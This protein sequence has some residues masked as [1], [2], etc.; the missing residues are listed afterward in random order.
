MQR[1]RRD[2]IREP[3]PGQGLVN[4]AGPGEITDP[5]PPG[6]QSVQPAG[7]ERREFP[8]R[9]LRQTLPGRRHRLAGRRVVPHYPLKA[10]GNRAE[11]HAALIQDLF[12]EIRPDGTPP[13]NVIVGESRGAR[14]VPVVNEPEKAERQDI[15]ELLELCA[16]RGRKRPVGKLPHRSADRDL[17]TP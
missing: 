9:Q 13:V 12:P 17:A 6:P 3:E 10:A 2:G 16:L 1:V 14:G 5:V 11:Q 15:A 8:R 7:H 4:R